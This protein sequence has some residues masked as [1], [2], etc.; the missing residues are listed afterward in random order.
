MKKDCYFYSTW[1][2][3]HAIIP[4]CQYDKDL[5]NSKSWS[6][7]EEDCENC[8]QYFP[9]SLIP[10]A[11]DRIIRALVDPD[12]TTDDYY[13]LCEDIWHELEELRNKYEKEKN[14]G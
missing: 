14:N 13:S 10:N 2:D 6:I 11:T 12:Y 8:K 5:N 9:K 1:Q 7:C 4:Y 3:M